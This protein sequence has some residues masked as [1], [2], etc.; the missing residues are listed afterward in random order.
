MIPQYS[1]ELNS[2]VQFFLCRGQDTHL[3]D[4]AAGVDEDETED[5]GNCQEGGDEDSQSGVSGVL[6]HH[7]D[8]GDGSDMQ[9]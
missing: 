8:D 2:R 3:D 9:Q 7:G 6:G 4:E 5:E 1:G